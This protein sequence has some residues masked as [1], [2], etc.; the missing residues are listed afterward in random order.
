MSENFEVHREV[1]PIRA[2]WSELAERAR[3]DPFAMPGWIETWHRSFDGGRLEVH[4]LR[5]NGEL[6]ALAPLIGKG[7]VL[8]SPTNWHTPHYEI[9]ALDSEA[10]DSLI[11]HTVSRMPARLRIRFAPASG[12]TSAAFATACAEV[13]VAVFER[14][15]ARSPIIELEGD[16]ES[17]RRGLSKNM[18]KN[19]NRRRTRTEEL[20][21]LELKIIEGADELEDG[22][23]SAFA[24]E[25]SGWKGEQGTAMASEPRTRSFYSEIASWAAELGMLRLVLLQV[26]GHPIAFDL[27]LQRNG[28]YYSLKTGY[29]AEHHRLGPGATLTNDLIRYCYAMGLDR[30]ALLG[31]EDEFKRK[32]SDGAGVDLVEIQA[33]R[34][35][36][37]LLD[38]LTQVEGKSLARSW[39]GKVRRN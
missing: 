35:P 31:S 1:E 39:V 9:L 33:F 16:F 21:E 15:M 25:A 38:R 3:S 17:Y 22:L 4:G 8:G 32:W 29:E 6:V 19:L 12:V 7:R 14:T 5:R 11:R 34:G 37:A 26:D 10:A 2:E 36:L 23:A 24:I 28:V 30:V 27:G 13:G 20:G 18:R